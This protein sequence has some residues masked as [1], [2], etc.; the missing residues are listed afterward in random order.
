MAGAPEPGSLSFPI[1]YPGP[2]RDG[3]PPAVDVTGYVWLGRMSKP[4]GEGHEH[5]ARGV[6]SSLDDF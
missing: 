5:R 3:E 1:P 2:P 6:I 4:M